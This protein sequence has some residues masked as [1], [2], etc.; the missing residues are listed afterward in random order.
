[1]TDDL[2]SLDVTLD[3][4]ALLDELHGAFTRYAVLPSG[5]AADAVTLWTAATHAQPA[6]E[7]ATRLNATS[8]EKRCGKSR[9]LDI[10]EATCHNPLITVNISA[11]AL[12]RS[13]GDDPPVLILDEADTVF[14]KGIKGDEKSETLRGLINAG[15]QRNRPYIRWDAA[16]RQPEN[17][18]TFAMAALAAIGRLPDTITDRA[19]NI[20]M[21]RRAPGE[22]VAPFRIR[23]DTPAL[24]GLR[25]RLHTW[26]R[27]HLD[28]L[29]D[30]EPALPVDDRAADNWMPLVAVADLAGGDWPARARKAAE[31]LTREADN[32]EA[33]VSLSLRLLADL[34]TVFGDAHCLYTAT[35]LERLHKLDEAP[36]GNYYG[37]P[38]SARDLGDR[39]RSYEVR[40]AMSGRTG[41]ARTARDTTATTSPGSGPGTTPATWATW[42]TSQVRAFLMS[43]MSRPGATWAT[44]TTP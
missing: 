24:H 1:M 6:W 26:A 37:R 25:D 8:P 35:I 17:C 3:G 44:G 4:A 29:R 43:R 14:G 31:V 40:S 20:R 33:D 16:T 9:L 23:R 2:A 11:A 10:I 19:V 39:L 7:H 32:A 28:G 27:P 5:E 13:V 36:W 30:A 42:A 34:Q 38:F 15:H 18:P 22:R 21:Q 41:P 12:A